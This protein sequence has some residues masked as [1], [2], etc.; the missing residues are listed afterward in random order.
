MLSIIFNFSLAFI[1]EYPFFSD[2]IKDSFLK[3][4]RSFIKDR[5]FYSKKNI[6]L[7]FNNN[8]IKVSILN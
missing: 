5:K 1:D 6:G 7:R 2:D 3:F 4:F 8:F